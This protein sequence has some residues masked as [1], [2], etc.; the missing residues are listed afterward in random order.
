M[1]PL[2]RVSSSPVPAFGDNGAVDLTQGIRGDVDGRIALVSPP[3]IYK[4]LIITG[5]NNGE[6]A[7]SYG[8]YGDIRAWNVRTG[9]L[10][11]SFHTVPR[12]GEPGIDTWEGDSWKNRS[13]TNMWSYFTIDEARGIVYAPIGSPTSDY[14]G[15]D[16]KGAGLYGNA[17]VA[18][19][20]TTGKLKW[21]QQLVH[22]DLW[23]YDLPAAPTLID[24]RRGGKMPSPSSRRWPSCSY[25]IASPARPCSAW[26]NGGCRKAPCRERPRRQR[27]P[28]R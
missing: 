13:G 15:G 11:W 5:G 25:S 20:A 21:Y 1:Q 9:K 28:S 2:P 22:H 6:Q 19:D 16:R 8:L 7:P 17:V 4:D 18:L 27:S 10:I 3:A 14:Y 12:P 23:D 26:K 24:V